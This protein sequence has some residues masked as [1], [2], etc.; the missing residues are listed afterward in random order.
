MKIKSG[1]EVLLLGPRTYLLP[2]RGIIDS[3]FGKLPLEK[4]AGKS[5][6]YKLKVGKYIFTVVEPTV[7]DFMQRKTKRGP[8]VVLPKDAS[9]IA[10]LTGAGKNWKVLDAGAGSG[11][12]SIFLSNIGCD[13]TAYEVRK[14]FYNVA[15]KNVDICKA[16]VNVFNRDVTKGITG[17]DFDLVTLD[18]QHPEKAIKHA[19]KALRPGGWLAVY[20]MHVEEVR[21]A[22]KEIRKHSFT[23]PRIIEPLEREWQIEGNAKTFMR[24]R[25]H[26]I[27][28]TGFLTITR[29]V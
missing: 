21:E 29:K 15:K 2:A 9:L 27:A 25:N 12:M 1:Q 8:Q 5:F 13:V 4:L 10:A 16:K 26:M 20:S 14:D 17:K 11:F 22:F 6:G 28:H 19:H 24:P 3:K 18:M 7:L 23:K